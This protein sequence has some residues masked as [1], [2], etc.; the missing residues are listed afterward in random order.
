MNDPKKRRQWDSCDPKISYEIPKP[1]QTGDFFEIYAPVFKRESR[2]SKKGPSP[3]LGSLDSTRE[4]VE[5]FYSYWFNFE[6][7][8]T[9]ERMDEED[10]DNSSG[11]D[12]KRWLDRKNRNQRQKL[13]KVNHKLIMLGGQCKNNEISRTSFWT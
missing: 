8:R 9:F 11:R 2:F 10:V 3:P 13:K 4:E 1:N 5:E 12:E 7:W 6:S